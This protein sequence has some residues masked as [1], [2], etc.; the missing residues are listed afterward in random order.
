MKALARRFVWWP[1]MDK[2][3]EERV[4][5]CWECQQYQPAPANA[6]L[7][8]WEW[9]FK[10][11]SRLHVDFAGPVEGHMLLILVDAYSKWIE[12]CAVKSTTLDGVMRV[13][14]PCLLGL[15]CLIP[16]CQTMVRVMSVQNLRCFWDGME[17]GM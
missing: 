12:V 2:Q 3:I 1:L 17:S 14:T 8:P 4:K 9:P 13:C 11:W 16:W 15:G 7:H 6:P 5:G 10:P